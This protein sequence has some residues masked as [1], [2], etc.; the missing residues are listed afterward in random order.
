MTEKELHDEQI[1]DDHDVFSEYYL[2]IKLKMNKS[3]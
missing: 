1:C 2:Q 3:I